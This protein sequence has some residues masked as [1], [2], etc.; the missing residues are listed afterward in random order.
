MGK[1]Q[2]QEQW[3]ET[4]GEQQSGWSPA[5]PAA[6]AARRHRSSAREQPLGYFVHGTNL[7]EFTCRRQT[8]RLCVTRLSSNR[9]PPFPAPPTPT[10]SLLHHPPFQ[11][12]TYRTAE[13]SEWVELNFMTAAQR[14]PSLPSPHLPVPC[15][16][17]W[18]HFSFPHFS[19]QTPT[20]KDYS[21]T[22]TPTHTQELFPEPFPA[23]GP[24]RPATNTCC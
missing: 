11:V 18:A 10:L 12:S 13:K 19:T 8:L 16:P 23:S 4:H 3:R 14:P 15:R 22:H 5:A 1:V 7:S 2:P 24:L 17:L 6:P 9:A 20:A 21:H